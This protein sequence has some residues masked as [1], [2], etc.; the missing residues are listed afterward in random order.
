VTLPDEISHTVPSRPSSRGV[1]RFGTLAMVGNPASLEALATGRLLTLFGAGAE[2]GRRPPPGRMR[3]VVTLGDRSVSSYHAQITQ[4]NQGFVIED[5]G[6][7]NGTLVDGQR[8]M[9]PTLMREGAVLFL[10]SQVLVFR[11]MTGAEISAIESDVSDPFAPVA[12][13]SPTLST[14]CAKLRLLAPSPSELFLLGETG[15]GKEVFANAIHV[16]SGRKG[17]LMAI[18]C[19]AL[20]RELVESELFGYER[21]A[22]ST[23]KERKAG[24]IES[25]EGGTLFLDELA[26]MPIDVQS[27]LLRFLQDRKYMAIGS[28]RL[29]TA[30]VRIIAASS[31][32]A[33]ASGA[34]AIQDAL[35]GRLGA[36]PIQLPPLRD[37]LEDLGRLVS[38]FLGAVGCD[39]PLEAEAFQALFLYNW[40]HNIRELQKV[41]TEAELLSRGAASI[42]IDHLP[43]LIV[44]TLDFASQR[45]PT[46]PGPTPRVPPDPPRQRRPVPTAEELRLLMHQFH[47]NVAHVSSHLGRQWAVISRTLRRYGIDPAEFRP[48]GVNEGDGSGPIGALP[49]APTPGPTDRGMDAEDESGDEG[50]TLA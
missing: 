49:E 3:T 44:D 29:D 20:P 9:K 7:T 28:T 11:T 43:A 10:G 39:R 24:L 1:E 14:L 31:R 50:D 37:R 33:R 32:V 40:P 23:A 2:I 38:Y 34:P 25:A 48:G 16:T 41:I 42:G 5:K 21:G 6:S 13:L 12:T 18:N 8:I 27:K 46:G 30:N 17:R 47:G 15:V 19:A 35:L 45:S 22:H 4:E 26:E 36:Q